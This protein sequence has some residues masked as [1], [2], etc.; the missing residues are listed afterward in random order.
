LK[1]VVQFSLYIRGISHKMELAE[2]VYV[3]MVLI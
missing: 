3:S 1:D 2:F